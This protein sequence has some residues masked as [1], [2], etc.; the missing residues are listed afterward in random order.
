MGG[1]DFARYQ[2]KVPGVIAFMGIQNEACGACWPQ[3]H[4]RF[5]VDESALIRGAGLYVQTA[6]DFLAEGMQA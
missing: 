5:T 4:D 2:E 3:H 1:E 6:L